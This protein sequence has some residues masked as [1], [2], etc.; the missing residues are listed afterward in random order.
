MALLYME[1]QM[2]VCQSYQLSL[3]LRKSH[4]LPKCFEFV[5]IDVCSDGNCPTLSKHQLLEHWPQ[6][7]TVHDVAKL[8]GLL[9]STENP[10][11]ILNF[12]LLLFVNSPQNLNILMLLHPTGQLQCRT[13]SAMSWKPFSQTHLKRFDHHCLIVL[14]TDFS[15][16]GFGYVICQADDNKA[17]TAA[18]DAYQTRF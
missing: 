4:I 10:S 2:R 11:L 5:G 1:Y 17:S 13:T 18:M 8:I 3:S 9:N 14:K 16:H 12:E 15:S 7:E 6:P